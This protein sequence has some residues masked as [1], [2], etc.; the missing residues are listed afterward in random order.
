MVDGTGADARLADLL[1][2]DGRVVDVLQPGH[3][4]SADE[5]L[6]A[7]GMVVS[8]GFIDIHTHSDVIL[9]RDGRGQSK[10]LQGVTTEVTGNCS[11]SSFPN[12]LDRAELHADHIARIG[13]G[14]LVP[15]WVDLDGYADVLAATG[16]AINVAPLMGHGTLRVAVMGVADRVPDADELATMRRLTERAM[17]QGAF[18]MS[19]GLTHVPSAYAQPAE[20]EALAEVI[21]DAGRLYATHARAVAGSWTGA[22]DEAVAVGRRTGGRVQFSHI[23]INEPARWGEAQGLLDVLDRARADDVDIA[24]DVYPYDASCSSLT[25]Y[26]PGWLQEGGSPALQARLRDPSAR[27]RAMADME[28]GFWG[29]MP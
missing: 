6:D 16:L 23:A 27:A 22:I 29:G 14:P 15:T 9:V 24:F 28:R 20:I 1:L 8:P 19:T 25:Q 12:D 11:F 17:E 13:D 26:L 3:L 5:T 4:V 7:S 18:G 10:V 21:A 2:T